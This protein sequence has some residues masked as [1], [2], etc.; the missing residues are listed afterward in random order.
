MSVDVLR[1]HALFRRADDAF[2]NTLAQQAHRIKAARRQ[3][4]HLADDPAERFF[5]I[6]DGWVKLFRETIDG[7]EA[8]IDI[9]NT[10]KIFGESAMFHDDTYPFSA[11]AASATVLWS[12]PL[13]PLKTQIA[14]DPDFAV[15]LLQSMA[16]Y[17]R[18]QDQELE[19]RT[20]QNAPQRIGCF[21]LRLTPQEDMGPATIHLPYDKTLVASRLG[22]QPETFSRA[23]SKLKAAINLTVRGSTI[24]IGS[25]AELAQYSCSACSSEFPCHDLKA[26]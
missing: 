19:H 24:E 22:M 4:I 7:S 25:V 14:R 5:L 8:V 9:L 3:V 17:R 18:L 13:K 6:E 10:G 12:F 1:S 26:S 15:S 11:E 2:L 20:L 23:L 21:L 16:H